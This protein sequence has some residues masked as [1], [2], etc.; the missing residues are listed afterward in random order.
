MS[1]IFA[2]QLTAVATV[3]LAVLARA[4]A[5]LAD[6][7]LPGEQRRSWPWRPGSGP[8]NDAGHGPV[9]VACQVRTYP[10]P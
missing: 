8:E 1:L 4:A 7:A 6:L 5:I 2:A 9:T 3:A 10:P